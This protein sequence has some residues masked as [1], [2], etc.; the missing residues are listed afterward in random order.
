MKNKYKKTATYMAHI[1]T[2]IRKN[3]CK[4]REYTKALKNLESR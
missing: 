1:E 3:K 2:E 4:V